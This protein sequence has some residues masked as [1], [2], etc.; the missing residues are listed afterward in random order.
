MLEQVHI[1]NFSCLEYVKL[2]RIDNIIGRV[3]RIILEANNQ[4]IYLV[5]FIVYGVVNSS[6][7]Y[8]DEL[9]SLTDK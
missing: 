1:T 4:P 5:N 2:K 7:F 3:T 9:E 8:E 6:E